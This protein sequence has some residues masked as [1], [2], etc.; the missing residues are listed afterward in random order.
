MDAWPEIRAA[1]PDAKLLVVGTG[2]DE[3]RLRRR[4][5]DEGLGGIEFCGR[6]NDAER[7]RMSPIVQ[8]PILP[9]QTGRVGLARAEAASFGVPVFRVG[10][11][12]HRGVISGWRR[13]S[14]G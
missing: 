10:G 13:R 6:L 5:R 4:V 2:N 9:F 1:V 3:R 12:S 7:D 14:T 11:H 8:A